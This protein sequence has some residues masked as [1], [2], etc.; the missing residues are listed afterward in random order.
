MDSGETVTVCWVDNGMVYGTFASQ[1][2]KT[3]LASKNTENPIT[4]HIHTVGTDI[5]Q[6]RDI[7]TNMWFE[8]QTDWV[9]WID[10]DIVINIDLYKMLCEKADKKDAPVVSGIYL[11][12]AEPTP[13]PYRTYKNPKYCVFPKKEF[14]LFT[15]KLEQI[16]AAGLGLVLIHKSVFKKLKNKYPTRNFYDTYTENGEYVGED[17]SFF[18]KIESLNIPIF[19][20]TSAIAVHLKTVGIGHDLSTMSLDILKNKN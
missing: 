16:S 6:N 1:L 3:V 5:N 14:K 12:D 10:S 4:E 11:I 7:A 9:L 8:N 19:V 17:V 18:K 20:H 13:Y 2:L 15:N